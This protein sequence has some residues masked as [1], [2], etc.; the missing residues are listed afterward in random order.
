MQNLSVVILGSILIGECFIS[1]IGSCG[2]CIFF[3]SHSLFISSFAY[4]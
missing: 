3:G 4:L 1:Q 2:I